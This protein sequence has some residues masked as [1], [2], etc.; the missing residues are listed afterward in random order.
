MSEE[1]EI[2]VRNE[3]HFRP[4]NV[5]R[6]IFIVLIGAAVATLFGLEVGTLLSRLVT[7]FI[8]HVDPTGAP[9][10]YPIQVVASC[11]LGFFLGSGLGNLIYNGFERLGDKWRNLDNG[12]KIT[13][14]VGV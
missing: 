12:D 1:P 5:G 4:N 2:E 8:T 7:R 9:A 6:Y 14:V 10:A 11:L 3:R 13:M